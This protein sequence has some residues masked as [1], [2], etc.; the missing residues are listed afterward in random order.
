M[1][2][3]AERF[4]NCQRMQAIQLS[5]P[6]TKRTICRCM[7]KG[8]KYAK[9]FDVMAR[10]KRISTRYNTFLT[11]EA[12]G[13]A[14]MALAND[15]RC[16]EHPRHMMRVRVVEGKY[17]ADHVCDSRC[18]GAIGHTCE[19]SCGGENHGMDFL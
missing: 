4:A 3:I 17:N 16:P 5:A 12:C 8:C 1:I 19:C 11:R 18:T 15:Q 10:E 2:D 13:S 6:E 14:L 9:A 7:V